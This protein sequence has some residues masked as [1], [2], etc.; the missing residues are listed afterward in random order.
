MNK[1]AQKL[2]KLGR[3]KRKNFSLS[4]LRRRTF[5]LEKARLVKQE[6]QKLNGAKNPRVR[7]AEGVRKTRQAQS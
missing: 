2:G 1:A 5:L 4:E 6:K 7:I 3:G